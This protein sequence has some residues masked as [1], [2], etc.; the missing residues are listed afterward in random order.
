MCAAERNGG[1]GPTVIPRA[2]E[3]AVIEYQPGLDWKPLEYSGRFAIL[4]SKNCE[5][6]ASSLEYGWLAPESHILRHGVAL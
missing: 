6:T 1:R 5:F 2:L 4:H 3:Y